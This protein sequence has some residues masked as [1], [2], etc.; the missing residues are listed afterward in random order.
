MTACIR[1]RDVSVEFPI[2]Q[3]RG[4]SLRSNMLR[5]VGGPI[6]RHA[7]DVVVV[8]ALSGVD[9]EI[10]PGQRIALVGHNGAGKSTLLRVL[11]GAYEPTGGV[12]HIRGK[13]SSL[14]DL[15]VGLDVELT[16]REN[17]IMRGVF[18]GMSFAE[19]S[20]K[21]DEVTA[22]S[23]LG[24]Y[25]DLPMRTYSSGMILRLAFAVATSVQPEILLLDEI[26]GVGDTAFSEKAR[27]RIDALIGNAS[28][29]ILASHDAEILRRHC[30]H[31]L[32]MRNGRIEAKGS[33]DE[34]LAAAKIR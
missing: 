21:V 11:S 12:A 27:L 24:D 9:L 13:V 2:Y 5:R 6:G 31:A 14:L 16:G 33:L 1:L 7:S 25:I 32:L 4:R 26:V 28:I 34:V 18:L 19:A 15:S 17:I 3:A 29:L 20:R 30:N 8:K 10:E 23:E 22:F